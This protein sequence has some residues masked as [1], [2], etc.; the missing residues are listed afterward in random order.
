MNVADMLKLTPPKGTTHFV[1]D[2]DGFTAAW[3][4]Q[5]GATLYGQ[6]MATV[7]EDQTWTEIKGGVRA[8][9]SIRNDA[10]VIFEKS[11][12]GG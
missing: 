3:Y 8:L 6:S 1:L 5:D 11:K 7:G 9:R 10:E 2:D 12:M 4:M